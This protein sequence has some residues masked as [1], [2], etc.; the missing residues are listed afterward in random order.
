MRFQTD[1]NREKQYQKKEYLA[2]AKLIYAYTS[3]H[4]LHRIHNLWI[5]GCSKIA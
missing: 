2:P 1:W 5:Q 4:Q 3:N